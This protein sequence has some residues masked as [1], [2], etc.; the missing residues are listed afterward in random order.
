MSEGAH[1]IPPLFEP[2][3]KRSDVHI[4]IREIRLHMEHCTRAWIGLGE[5]RILILKDD[6]K[7]ISTYYD[8]EEGIFTFHDRRGGHQ[9]V[10]IEEITEIA[11][12]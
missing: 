5:G 7:R 8:Y 10:L 3:Y 12:F 9:V 2:K 11:G 4:I 1:E 6:S